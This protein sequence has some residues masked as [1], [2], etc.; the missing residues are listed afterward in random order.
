MGSS[1][2]SVDVPR[3]V[4]LYQQ[5]RLKLDELITKRYAPEQINEAIEAVERGEALR[6]VV[7]WEASGN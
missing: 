6:N 3:L 4:D 5:G 1:N 7:M 2:L